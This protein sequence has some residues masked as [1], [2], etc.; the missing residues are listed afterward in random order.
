MKFNK[1]LR[2]AHD[3]STMLRH[4]NYKYLKTEVK[5]LH[6][7]VDAGST[8]KEAAAAC[9]AKQLAVELA[10]VERYWHVCLGDLQRLA[11]ELFAQTDMVLCG[12]VAHGVL[13]N[14]LVHLELLEPLR[15]W[16]SIA[17]LADGLRRHRLLQITAVVKI[18]K[19]FVKALEASL[20]RGRDAADLLRSSVLSRGDIHIL[21]EHLEAAGDAMLRLG[22]GTV[23]RE[24]RD[25]CSICLGNLADPA[26]LPCGHRYC[27]NCVLP[28]FDQL[29]GEMR[30]S[31]RVK[32]KASVRSST[33]TPR[34]LREQELDESEDGGLDA[35]LLRC[36]LCRAAGPAVP[37]ALRLDG[38]VAR[39]GRGLSPQ[40]G[41][42]RD[43]SADD[44]QQF[45]AVVASS[46]ARLAARNTTP[47]AAITCRP[48]SSLS[49]VPEVPGVC[50]LTKGSAVGLPCGFDD[51]DSTRASSSPS[52]RRGA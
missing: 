48:C 30:S 1:Y 32:K 16:L 6:R 23:R 11:E 33:D 28:L 14:P 42:P 8:S 18:E 4:L 21:C 5:R 27:I 39:L 3:S 24:F 40:F 26:R 31:P 41:A 25:P 17:A 38:L 13:D 10:E 15:S 47:S 46:L 29:P 12:D 37:Q 51:M 20:P 35:A 50:K 45:T 7:L 34:A 9:F 36:P 43:P 2:E 52:F 22:L 19:K 49:R 44:S